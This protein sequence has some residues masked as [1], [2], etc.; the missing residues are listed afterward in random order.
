ML[1]FLFSKSP[2][3]HALGRRKN[4]KGAQL[5]IYCKIVDAKED[6]GLK[7]TGGIEDG[8]MWMDIRYI[9]EAEWTGWGK[10]G[11]NEKEWKMIPGLLALITR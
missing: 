3:P 9:V 1:W 2:S 7:Q 6:G 8:E 11:V 5:A 4:G 10:V